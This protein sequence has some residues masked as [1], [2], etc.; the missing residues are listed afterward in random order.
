MTASVPHGNEAP[1]AVLFRAVDSYQGPPLAENEISLTL[2]VTL[3]PDDEALTEDRIEAYR[4]ELVRVLQ[5]Q[6]GIG[7]R[8]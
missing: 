7:I 5:E 2:R 1:A 4:L 6:L 8:G 3:Q